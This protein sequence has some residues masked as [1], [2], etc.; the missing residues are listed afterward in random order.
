MGSMREAAK[1]LVKTVAYG[2]LDVIT[3]HRG[4]R[5]TVSGEA[6]IFPVRWSRYYPRVYEPEKF[7]FIRKH[8]RPGMTAVDIGAHIGLFSVF[9][10]KLVG[11]SGRVLSFEPTPL[12]R[13][14][15]TETVRLNHCEANVEI[16]CE[17]VSRATGTATF[18]D[19]GAPL[20]NANSLVG[21]VAASTGLEVPTISLDDL[22]RDQKLRVGFLK[23][24]A[25]GG[26]LEI[27]EGA[28]ETLR[29]DR[30]FVQLEI[31]PRPLARHPGAL[32]AVWQLCA[33]VGMRIEQEGKVLSHSH[34]TQLDEAVEL[35]LVPLAG[36]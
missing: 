33:D 3:R 13:R 26:E 34:F 21:T 5:R 30:P 7:S 1:E 28:R 19:T 23:I 11:Q 10:S 32:A 8:C 4:L 20:S 31:H 2:A 17:A 27:L 36:T 14:V 29:R 25:E 35:Q 6:I 16:H 22:C 15:L 12:T 18:F 24:D 9:M